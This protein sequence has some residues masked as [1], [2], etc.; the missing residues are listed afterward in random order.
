MAASLVSKCSCWFLTT[1]AELDIGLFDS[2][3]LI[4]KFML[5]ESSYLQLKGSSSSLGRVHLKLVDETITCLPG[6]KGDVHTT[7]EGE[8]ARLVDT[9]IASVKEAIPNGKVKKDKVVRSVVVHAAIQRGRSD[10]IEVKFD[11]N[12]VV[13]IDEEGQPKA[14][15]SCS[16]CLYVVHVVPACIL[17]VLVE[18]LVA[19]Y[20]SM[21]KLAHGRTAKKNVA[22]LYQPIIF[23]ADSHSFL[24][25]IKGSLIDE[26]HQLGNPSFSSF[27]LDKSFS[28]HVQG[29]S[30]VML[31]KWSKLA[32]KSSRVHERLAL[33]F[34][35]W[36][37]TLT[38]KS[39][40]G[41][42]SQMRAGS[43]FVFHA[44]MSTRP[45]RKFNP[46]SEYHVVAILLKSNFRKYF[47]KD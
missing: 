12:A 19:E 13:I 43:K 14:C 28:A 15:R 36:V 8:G 24:L 16:S 45:L 4:F 46:V 35:K 7:F 26:T 32:L 27:P 34:V 10:G 38:L 29:T 42:L 18:V 25:R 6:K 40:R 41:H 44:S 21:I 33:R 23:Q 31:K 47:E 37:T 5:K 2:G 39:N 30:N 3:D 9:I 22:S 17:P 20:R 1:L 11:D